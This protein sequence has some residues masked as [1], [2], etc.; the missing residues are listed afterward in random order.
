MDELTL[1]SYCPLITV[2]HGT[3]GINS[4]NGSK[5]NETTIR[6]HLDQ[7]RDDGLVSFHVIGRGGHE[8]GHWF[9]TPHGVMKKFPDRLF[10]PSWLTESHLRS[11]WRRVE[12]VDALYGTALDL[13]SEAGRDWYHGDVPPGFLGMH[14]IRGPQRRGRDARASGIL[15]TVITYEGGI[16]IFACH[17]GKQL[18]ESMMMEKWAARFQGLLT[19]CPLEHEDRLSVY[20]D[21]RER[22]WHSLWNPLALEEYNT[23]PSGYLVIADD[24]LPLEIAR[25]HLCSDRNGD[26]QPF[27]FVKAGADRG[28][29][30]GEVSPRPFDLAVSMPP[31]LHERTR[32]LAL[33]FRRLSAET[34][35]E[36]VWRRPLVPSTIADWL[37]PDIPNDA[38][39]PKLG[40]PLNLGGPNQPRHP[41]DSLGTALR[42]HILEWAAEWS[43]LTVGNLARLS[44]TKK[45]TVE[46]VCRHMTAEGWLQ[47]R[48]GMLYLGETGIM[49]V[50]RRDRVAPESVRNRV[51][52]EM[53]E[54]HRVV[55]GLRLHTQAVNRTMIACREARL[56][57]FAGWRLVR[58]YPELATQLKPDLV[59]LA[60]SLLGQG[61]HFIEVERTAI[62]PERV[63]GKLD[64]YAKVNGW[65]SADMMAHTVEI[66]RTTVL[67]YLDTIKSRV[68]FI[69]ETAAAELLFRRLGRGLPMFTATMKDVRGGKLEGLDTVWRLDGETQPVR[70]LP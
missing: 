3:K 21:F 63:R 5:F 25:Q 26:E 41:E 2:E 28:I 16:R 7:L 11:L 69:T 14:H 4:A 68:I 52:N 15:E 36:E 34:P 23:R 27:L 22:A 58:D 48:G 61:L 19:Y 49:Y 60:Q 62:D 46:D 54:D 30:V 67:D 65:E 64:P 17:L 37:V 32:M 33:P 31:W 40:N 9:L 10:V 56:P 47:E 1:L 51:N 20:S 66:N 38:V 59:I 35:G 39:E 8:A 44:K 18:S 45:K 43:G 55:G 57:V 53:R 42:A 24:E 50:A 12:R 13:F 70:R 29:A 6:R